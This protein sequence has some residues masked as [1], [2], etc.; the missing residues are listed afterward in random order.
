MGPTFDIQP[1]KNIVTLW[2]IIVSKFIMSNAY[3]QI[4]MWKN[5]IKTSRDQPYSVYNSGLS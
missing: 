1:T 4:I 2:T 3:H 5:M